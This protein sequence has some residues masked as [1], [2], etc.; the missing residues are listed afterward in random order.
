V[1]FSG[2]FL[3]VRKMDCKMHSGH[4]H[5]HGESC[6]HPAVQH[7][8]HVDYA[9][10]N[11]LHHQHGEH[12]DEHTLEVNDTNAAGCTPDHKCAGHDVQ[13]KH[14]ENCGHAAVPHGDHVDYI[15]AGHLHSPCKDHC[16]DHGAVATK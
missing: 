7:G 14:T 15:V 9:H 11:H 6:G 16:D 8:D 12:V 4:D 13:H 2:V 3:G 10:D 1:C 5:K